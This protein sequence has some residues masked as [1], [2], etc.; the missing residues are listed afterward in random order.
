M[1]PAWTYPPRVA[2]PI[3][4]SALAPTDRDLARLAGRFGL[5]ALE[6]LGGFEN[7]LLR[8]VEPPRRVVRLTH[9]SRRSVELVEAEVAFMHHLAEHGIS[10][11][12]PI[13]SIDAV[14]AE[15]FLL[16][17]GS[18]TVA[19]CMSEAP[20]TV[21]HPRDWSD[22]HLV[23]MGELLGRAHLAAA[24]FE[25]HGVRRPAW[26]DAAFD[27]GTWLLNDPEFSEA[28]RSVRH[29]A[30]GHPAGGTELLIH[31]DAHFGNTHIDDSARLTLFDFDDCAYGTAV[32][33]IAMVLF[34]W[35][36]VGW[37]DEVAATRR[38][39]DRLLDG[40]RRHTDLAEDWPEGVDR[41]L[42]VREADI[43]LLI[44]LNEVEWSDFEQRWM[45]GRRRR[46]M[47]RIPLLG[48]PLA[49]VLP[50]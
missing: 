14:P 22:A 48:T 42:K 34:Y 33:D 5:S 46:V 23:A 24:T 35:L 30:A 49:D 11:A 27:P 44:S 13:D 41:L 40:Y 45:E 43:F 15:P 39:F 36:M 4:A 28:W 2:D 50:A 21:R 32:H 38:F 47:D 17:D 37:D 8:S 18:P 1:R 3:R 26:T 19:Y 12:K 31:Q 9:T 7:L 10:A 16:D 25:P 20:G 6:P 29:H